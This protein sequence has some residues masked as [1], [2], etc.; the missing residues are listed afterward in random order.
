MLTRRWS[1]GVSVVGLAA[2]VA[3]L[4]GATGVP[5][6]LKTPGAE[7]TSPLLGFARAV[8]SPV[9]DFAG[10]VGRLGGMADEN[11]SLRQQLEKAKTDIAGLREA[12]EENR[13]LRALLGYER[14][15]PGREYLPARVIANDPNGLLRTI[16]IDRGSDQGVQKGQV[17]VTDRGMAGKVIAV[18]PRSAKL[19]LTVDPASVIN[20][21]VQRSRV[22]GVV[23]G[24]PD[25]DLLM[26][27]VDKDADVKEG[28]LVVTSGLGGGYPKG[29][30][31]GS[32]KKVTNEDQ[33]PFKEVR[34]ASA[35]TSGPLEMVM[36][37]LD[38]VPGEL[39]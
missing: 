16:V 18:Y 32:V 36:V 38:F 24:R 23:A 10:N 13:Q 14:D 30:V 37:V 20:G 28:D 22:P 35:A 31:L 26:R 8:V 9:V 27:Y 29:I 39:P 21:V 33:A 4:A 17:A 15:N 34:V 2:G 5:A 3:V 1:V 19:L 11:H 6:L 12:G 7:A 25:G